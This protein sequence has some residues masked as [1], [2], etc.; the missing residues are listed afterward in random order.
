MESCSI[1]NRKGLNMSDKNDDKKK[2]LIQK[3]NDYIDSNL[4]DIESRQDIPPE[5]KSSKIIHLFSATCAGVAVQPIPFADI[6]ILTPI[7]AYMATRLASIH[8]VSVTKATAWENVT[9]I[10][11][12]VGLGL[13]A[14]QLVIGAYK[15]IIPF[16]GAVTTIP[17]VYG[18]TYAIGRILDEMYLRRSKNKDKLTPQEVKDI[19]KKMK[20]EGIKKGKDNRE[21]IKSH[22][23]NFQK[24]MNNEGFR[25]INNNIDN[26]MIQLVLNKI[27]LNQN[28]NFTPQEQIII[29]AIK[30]SDNELNDA[31]IEQISEKMS[32]YDDS[33]IPYLVSNIKGIVHE[34]EFVEIENDDGDLIFASLFTDT[35]HPGYDV[36]MFN[37]NTGENWEIQLKATNNQSYV[38][39]WIDNHPGGEIQVTNEI[40]EEMN[41]TPTGISNEDLTI[42][43]NDFVDRMIEYQ[44]NEK[45][46]DYFPIMFPVSVGFVVYELWR[47]FKK[48]EISKDEFRLLTIKSTGLKAS[49]LIVIFVLLSIPV[50]NVVTG[51]AL[52]AMLINDTRETGE[53]LLDKKNN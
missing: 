30:R 51:V 23:E 53:K 6:F 18:M 16:Y 24:K 32:S 48:G 42:S 50:V 11:K 25:Y 38:Q 5:E 3:I 39:D 19:W 20:K 2:N 10:G 4:L 36:K 40:A 31:S 35:N 49:K 44:N 34:I 52:I 13:L 21:E 43:V 45:I 28:Y 33:Q 37:T 15:T 46:W 26:V 1:S 8:G 22:G 17:L 7:Q 12:V 47:R 41:L 27:R 9:D 29:D 14:Q